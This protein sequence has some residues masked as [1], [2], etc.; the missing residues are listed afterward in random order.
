MVRLLFGGHLTGRE[1]AL[2]CP[3]A[4]LFNPLNHT[5][6]YSVEWVTFSEQYDFY[7]VVM[8]SCGIC[9]PS[10]AAFAA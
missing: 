10:S 9:I 5:R 4:T 6:M 2:H 1:E 3:L 8:Q 7:C